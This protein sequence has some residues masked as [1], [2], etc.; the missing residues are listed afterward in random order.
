MVKS[1]TWALLL[2]VAFCVC[3]GLS[4]LFLLP[5][6]AVAAEIWSDGKL[7]E[8]VDLSVDRVITVQGRNGTNTVTVEN[9]RISVTQADC[10]DRHCMFRGWCAGGVSIVCLPNRLEIRFTENSGLDGVVG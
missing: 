2:V 5:R 10:P 7:V 3:V 8:T 9:G 6:Q 4:V 1:R